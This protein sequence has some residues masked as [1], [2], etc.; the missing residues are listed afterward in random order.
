MQRKVLEENPVCISRRI[1]TGFQFPRFS[2]HCVRSKSPPPPCP[3]SCV[4]LQTVL[5]QGS[6][7]S[8]C[9][10]CVIGMFRIPF[11]RIQYRI[12]PDSS[13]PDTGQERK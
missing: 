1:I 11:F 12:V 10:A 13:L 2:R 5:R 8:N 7:C 6:K 4:E 3:Y 9:F